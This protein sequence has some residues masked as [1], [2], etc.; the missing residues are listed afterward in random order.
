QAQ[1]DQQRRLIKRTFKQLQQ[2]IAQLTDATDEVIDTL[3][4]KFRILTTPTENETAD[5]TQIES[6]LKETTQAL[7][8]IL[9]TIRTA[10]AYRTDAEAASKVLSGFSSAPEPGYKRHSPSPPRRYPGTRPDNEI[11]KIKAWFEQK[12]IG[13]E[14]FHQD[15]PALDH[16]ADQ[17]AAY[18][19]DNYK[20]LESYLGN[21]K[22]SSTNAQTSRFSLQTYSQIE[23]SIHNLFFKKLKDSFFLSKRYYDKDSKTLIANLRNKSNVR[24][25][26][27]GGWFERYVYT[28]II[29]Y[30][31]ETGVEYEVARNLHIFYN[32]G[33]RFE[34]D[35]FFLINEQPLLIECKTSKDNYDAGIDVFCRHRDRLGLSIDQCLFISLHLPSSG[36]EL[37]ES[38][39]TVMVANWQTFLS[40]VQSLVPGSHMPEAE[41]ED[42]SNERLEVA[43]IDASHG[44]SI[45]VL[46]QF[47]KKKHID[48]Q[49]EIRRAVIVE[50]IN[51]FSESSQLFTFNDLPVLIRERLNH[52]A[53][54]SSRTKIQGI[55]QGVRKS[56]CFLDENNLPVS[57]T[58]RPITQLISMDPDVIE[59]RF[60]NSLQELIEQF[61]DAD[62]F[63]KP[64]NMEAFEKI[65][66]A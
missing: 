53:H 6:K 13:L 45:V 26:L 50:L 12:E 8:Q 10:P 38:D 49:P 21:L 1:A 61:L 41:S 40:R 2:E 7:Q 34:L 36:I 48:I 23:I 65:V 5:L 54:Q 59:D 9:A 43:E 56:R 17:L 4:R 37:R 27:S 20:T 11:G 28:K 58:K 32:N 25:F 35:L 55:L 52:T 19:G 46:Q 33:D 64:D 16:V 29:D 47:F 62:F 14:K 22:R 42:D 63:E 57:H 3:N 18:L 31:D 30:L 51:L 24:D 60:L 66:H 39:S 44:E 15:E